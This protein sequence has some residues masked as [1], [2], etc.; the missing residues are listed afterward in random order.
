VQQWWFYFGHHPVLYPFIVAIKH[1]REPL[2]GAFTRNIEHHSPDS[3]VKKAKVEQKAVLQADMQALLTEVNFDT[4]KLGDLIRRMADAGYV[5][6]DSSCSEDEDM[7]NREEI[8]DAAM[9][10]ATSLLDLK[11]GEV[12]VCLGKACT[13][14]GKSESIEHA[15][16]QHWAGTG[17]AVNTCSCMG[18]CKTAANVQM[19][20]EKASMTTVTGLSTAILEEHG[21]KCVAREPA[22]LC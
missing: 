18:K 10:G 22:P 16:R 7:E 14:K 20:C 17:V 15:L 13:R 1:N 3:Q 6:D 5:E 2:P 21:V 9:G 8:L 11:K 4:G 12:T 19:Q